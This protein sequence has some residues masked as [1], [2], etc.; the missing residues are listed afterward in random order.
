MVFLS[1][2]EW[3]ALKMWHSPEML[4]I[5]I[6]ETR[7]I[8]TNHMNNAREIAR[9]PGNAFPGLGYNKFMLDSFE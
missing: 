1:D 6:I 8:E 3:N 9:S 5:I 2:D 7:R 4:F